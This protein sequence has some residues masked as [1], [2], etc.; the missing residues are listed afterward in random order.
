MHPGWAKLAAPVETAELAEQAPA[1]RCASEDTFLG[2]ARSIR[3]CLS[4][5]VAARI[6]IFGKPLRGRNLTTRPGRRIAERCQPP[7]AS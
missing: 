7:P 3:A 5:F 6:R 4:V 2:D 1:I